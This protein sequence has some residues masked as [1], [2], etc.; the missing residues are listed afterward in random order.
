MCT[1][2][3]EALP[4]VLPTTWLSFLGPVTS[5]YICVGASV[6]AEGCLHRFAQCAYPALL[7]HYCRPAVG[8]RSKPT[9]C[10]AKVHVVCS[11]MTTLNAA[12]PFPNTSPLPPL[13]I[14]YLDPLPP[15]PQPH[16]CRSLP[17][18]VPT[19]L[20]SLKSSPHLPPGAIGSPPSHM[21]HPRSPLLTWRA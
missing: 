16:Y 4:T 19:T 8:A 2:K 3:P 11:C 6:G 5:M 21:P 14:A 12:P 17:T 7:A 15:P 13:S 9:T 18:Q 1:L 10:A 20:L